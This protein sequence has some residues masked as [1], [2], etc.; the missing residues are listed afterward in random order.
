MLPKDNTLPTR[1]YEAKKILCPMGMEYEKIHAC[2][3]YILYRKQFES[4]HKCLR[5]G[6]SRCKVKHDES[7]EDYVKKGPPAKALWSLPI[8]PRYKRL[9]PMLMM[10]KTSS[11]MQMEKNLMDCYNM[12]S[13]HCNGRK[14]ILCFLSLGVIQ[15]ILDLFLQ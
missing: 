11:G 4:L 12:L 9:F 10:Q 1:H 13:I 7:E 8:I 5:C 14:L 15:K 2:P 6:V 3:N